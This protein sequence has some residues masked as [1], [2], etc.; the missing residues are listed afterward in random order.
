MT[1]YKKSGTNDKAI[2]RYVTEVD[3]KSNRQSEGTNPKIHPS[4]QLRQ[5]AH[6]PFSDPVK[7]PKKLTRKP[8][9]NG[10]LPPP[11]QVHLCHGGNQQITPSSTR[12]AH[13]GRLEKLLRSMRSVKVETPWH[14]AG[15]GR[16]PRDG[17]LLTSAG[18]NPAVL[19]VTASPCLMGHISNGPC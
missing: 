6:Q 3:H 14:V 11:H 13:N 4:K 2:V 17:P 18:C 9:V 10:I 1:F 15:A 5:R 12:K 16:E 19:S 7:E 8:D